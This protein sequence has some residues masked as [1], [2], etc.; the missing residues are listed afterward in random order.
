MAEWLKRGR[1]YL[2]NFYC[3]RYQGIVG[4]ID[5]SKC[6]GGCG[7]WKVETGQDFDTAILDKR[8]KFLRLTEPDRIISDSITYGELFRRR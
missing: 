1:D 3:M 2:T 4:L 8:C 6:G 7:S 5:T